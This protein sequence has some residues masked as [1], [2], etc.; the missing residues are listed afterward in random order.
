MSNELIEKC[1]LIE[2]KPYNKI[3]F[4]NNSIFPISVT[5]S[6]PDAVCYVLYTP[7]G[8]IV[9]TGDFVFDSTMMD[10]Y[11]TDIG[12]LAY[13][14]KQGVLC[15][16][17]ESMYADK[18]GFT[19]PGHKCASQFREILGRNDGRILFNIYES[20]IYRIQELLSEIEK[21]N[22]G[23]YRR[24]RSLCGIQSQHVRSAD[25]AAFQQFQRCDQIHADRCEP[26]SAL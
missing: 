19:S 14:G 13:I 8:A 17:N 6:I 20:Q 16:M 7:D 10:S 4:G 2:I 15:L 25:G 12:K 21:T 3:V 9:Y 26:L 23:H 22:S 5:H 18:K 1:N 24:C 11:K